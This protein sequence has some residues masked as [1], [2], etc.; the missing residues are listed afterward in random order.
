M[1]NILPNTLDEFYTSV[2]TAAIS[3]LKLNTYFDNFDA[4]RFNYDGI[5]HS[6]EF[7]IHGR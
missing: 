5:D 3:S 7:D 2:L 1:F 4:G 6:L